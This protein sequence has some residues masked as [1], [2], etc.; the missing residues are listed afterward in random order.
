MNR[1]LEQFGLSK[2]AQRYQSGRSAWDGSDQTASLDDWIGAHERKYTT[3][4]SS[5]VQHERTKHETEHALRRQD[6]HETSP[7]IP[8]CPGARNLC[9]IRRRYG[10]RP[11]LVPIA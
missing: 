4:L 9:N 7:I 10:A 3:P 5:R 1:A 2:T 11:G 8:P 6:R